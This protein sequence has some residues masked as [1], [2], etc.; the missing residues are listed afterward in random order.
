ML[1]ARAADRRDDG[2]RPA[3]RPRRHRQARRRARGQ[4]RRRRVRAPPGASRRA[5]EPQAP[6]A[7][8]QRHAAPADAA[9]RS[10]TT[11]ARSTPIAAARLRAGAARIGRQKFTKALVLSTGA[12]VVE[13]DLQHHAREGQASRYSSM[14]LVRPRAARPDR[15]LAAADPV[16]GRA[17][18]PRDVA[19]R[20]S[21]WRCMASMYWVAE[22]NFP[23]LTFLGALVLGV[24]AVQ[25]L[26][27]GAARRVRHAHPAR[28]GAA[29]ALRDRGGPRMTRV[30][31]TGGAGFICS[32]LVP[33]PA[34]GHRPRG[35]GDGRAHVRGQHRT[36]SPTCSVTRA[37]RSSRATSATPAHVEEVVAGVDQIVNA[38]AESHV[39]KS[40]LDG[41]SEFVTTNVEGTQVLLD[42]CAR[43]PVERFILVSSCEVYGTAESD[44][45]DEEHP[46]NPRSPVRRDEGRR[47]P[48]R[49]QLRVHLRDARRGDPAVQQLRAVPAP[50]EGHAAVHHGGAAAIS[51]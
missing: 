23:G 45:M 26:I 8:H 37:C 24:L 1:H 7:R 28:R 43:H 19:P 11:A 9:S 10:R 46:L 29:P 21:R 40:I 34:A 14:R 51:R 36:T 15:L 32:N 44:P 49:L 47:R 38:A 3:E 22:S 6:V 31:V 16:G 27:L 30:L 12:S 2:R 33:A 13:V 48:P 5:D 18:R 17:Y 42:A 20:R 25:G 41:A 4:R 39:E 50:R 35:R